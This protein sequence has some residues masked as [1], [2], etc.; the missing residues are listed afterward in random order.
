MSTNTTDIKNLSTA[1]K[2]ALLAR[3]I[4]EKANRSKTCPLSFAQQRLWIL[5]QIAQNSPLYNM[6]FA[7]NLRGTL[8]VDA[9]EQSLNEIV[10]R[11]ESLRASFIQEDGTPVQ[12]I[13]KTLR[14]KLSILYL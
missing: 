12:V 13:A 5:D 11:H 3:L 9:L 6:P 7:I 1:E 2:R 10:R 14:L 4:L 8:N